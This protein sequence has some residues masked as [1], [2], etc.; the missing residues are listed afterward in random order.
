MFLSNLC[1]CYLAGD[2]GHL[3]LGQSPLVQ[4]S[5]HLV[6]PGFAVGP[7]EQV[8]KDERV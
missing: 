4:P 6:H 5:F 8:H 1:P 7:C 3:A 2:R